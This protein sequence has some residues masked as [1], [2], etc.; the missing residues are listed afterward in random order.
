LD[1][2]THNIYNALIGF[3]LAYAILSEVGIPVGTMLAGAGVVGLAFSLGA[4]GFVSDIVNG[5][6][7]LLE[8]QVD[9]GDDVTLDDITGTVVDVNLKT[10]TVKSFDGTLNFVPNRYITIVSNLSRE[11]MRTRI[12]IRMEPNVDMDKVNAIL[13]KVSQRLVP[14]H[15][16][17]TQE[18][19]SLGLIDIGNGHLAVRI[20]I[21]S[22][23]GSQYTVEYVFFQEYVIALTAEGI[24]IPA[25]LMQM[26]P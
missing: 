11:D 21:F 23:S 4:Q 14:L 7:I 3:F 26:T 20:D 19:V 10:T 15:P 22:K 5:F 17:I 2:L 25:T 8:K 9:I 12:N 1:N 18:P 24:S 16:E 13:E 6:F